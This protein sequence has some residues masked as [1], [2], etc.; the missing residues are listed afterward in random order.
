M[1]LW[2]AGCPGHWRAALVAG[3]EVIGSDPVCAV[4]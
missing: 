2:N 1:I 4:R 3:S